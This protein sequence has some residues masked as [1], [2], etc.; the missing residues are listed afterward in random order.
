MD[1]QKLKAIGFNIVD[2]FVN[3]QLAD[4]SMANVKQNHREGYRAAMEDVKGILA[5]V[6]EQLGPKPAFAPEVVELART[7]RAKVEA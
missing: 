1:E 3:R 5:P 7:P 4:K 6:K 2:G